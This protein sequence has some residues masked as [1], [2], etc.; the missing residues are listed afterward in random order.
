MNNYRLSSK[1]HNNKKVGIPQILIK[2]VLEME[3][4]YIKGK[5]GLR[6]IS[7]TSHKTLVNKQLFYIIAL[8][9][10]T[11]TIIFKGSKEC[12]DYFGVSV[13][14]INERLNNNKPLIKKDDNIEFILSRKPL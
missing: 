10:E 3:D 1:V 12:A 9:G 8:N 7:Q 11:N 4:I 13:F 6:Y 14:T 2:D 5:D